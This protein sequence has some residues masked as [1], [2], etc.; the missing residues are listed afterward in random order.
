[1]KMP[2]GPCTS[3]LIDRRGVGSGDDSSGNSLFFLGVLMGLYGSIGVNTGQNLQSSEFF[4]NA[5]EAE[6]NRTPSNRR[7]FIIGTTIFASAA[8]INFVAFSFAPT[9]VLQPLE[10]SQFIANVVF[11]IATR[12]P[13]LF[14]DDRE[15]MMH[16]QWKF[17]VWGKIGTSVFFR[18]LRGTGLIIVGVVLPVIA[19]LLITSNETADY[20]EESLWCV[21]RQPL[22][23]SYAVFV[24]VASGVL[25]LAYFMVRGPKVDKRNRTEQILYAI[26]AASAGAYMVVNAKMISEIINVWVDGPWTFVDML[27]SLIFIMTVLSIIVAL[28]GWLTLQQMGQNNYNPLSIIPLMQGSYIAFGSVAGGLLME[29][30]ARFDP[31]S[32]VLYW[33]GLLMVIVG[34]FLLV[35]P[36]RKNIVVATKIDPNNTESEKESLTVQ[37]S[38]GA[39]FM[40]VLLYTAKQRSVPKKVPVH[41]LPL[42]TLGKRP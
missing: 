20:D 26:P 6:S 13:D 24:I 14:K 2:L 27:T 22:W 34:C 15:S 21:W 17:W 4:G 41:T 5:G 16:S 9:S 32:H 37:A 35:P 1:M 33:S 39:G 25:T 19:T 23:I 3:E 8:I 28:A 12:N 11:N 18:I 36:P 30:L 7:W 38:F 29:E 10:G 31:I 42:L 40:P